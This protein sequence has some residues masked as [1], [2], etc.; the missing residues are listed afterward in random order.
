MVLPGYRTT[1]PT[2][3]FPAATPW[4]WTEALAVARPG[5]RYRLRRVQ[6]STT[7]HR[8]RQL[9]CAEGQVVTC[10]ANAGGLVL[11]EGPDGG[12]IA[13]ERALAWFIH[14]ETVQ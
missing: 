7:R 6:A 12:Q 2:Q 9:G 13:L 14:A 8:C 10:R 3:G 5:N 11:L 4:G 1:L